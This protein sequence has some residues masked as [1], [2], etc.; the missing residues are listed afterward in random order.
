MKQELAGKR[1]A[2][3]GAGG[4]I[5]R[6]ICETLQ[7]N[8]AD[9]IG[10]DLRGLDRLPEGVVGVECNLADVEQLGAVVAALYEEDAR[11]ISLV[12]SAGVVEENIGVE[13]MTIADFDRVMGVN[14]RGLF[15]AC[16]AFGRE[17]LA[18][19]GGGIV[20]IASMSGNYMVNYPQKQS[21]YNSSKAAVT[22]FTKSLAVEWAGRGVRV[23][24]LSPGYVGTPLLEQKT[25]MHAQ[26]KENILLER[27]A[28]PEEVAEAV[29]FLLSDR[30]T[31]FVGAEL[32]MDGG[33]TLR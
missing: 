8:G 27:F 31:Y 33:I 25:E 14:F 26:W 17:L 23:N 11:P 22:A 13:D 15:F 21:V 5:G 18:R 6:A 24:A 2:V 3:I 19:G 4:G 30:S 9:V 28:T 16:Q 1:V 12:N 10:L 7:A 20:N 29:L 32:L